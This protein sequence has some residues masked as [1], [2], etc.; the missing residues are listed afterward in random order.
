MLK[1]WQVRP[2]PY[3]DILRPVA[4]KNWSSLSPG[5]LL[6]V[7]SSVAADA[8]VKYNPDRSPLTVGITWFASLANLE[9]FLRA[10]DTCLRN[11]PNLTFLVV[12]HRVLEEFGCLPCPE[13]FYRY[14]C[15]ICVPGE[16]LH[17]IVDITSL[18]T[19]LSGE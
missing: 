13:R 11:H 8:P 7:K 1:L 19:I 4:K 2:V 3:L 9:N 10:Q 5:E 18:F 16:H 15:S 12:L 14:A 6:G 17:E